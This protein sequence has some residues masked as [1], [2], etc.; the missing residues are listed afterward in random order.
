MTLNR[1]R[2]LLASGAALLAPE[3]LGRL[4]A[5]QEGPTRKVL[6]FT[7]SAGYQHAVITRDDDQPALAERILTEAGRAHGFEVVATKDGRLFEPDRIG[8]WD[9]FAFYT[10]GD[11]TTPGEDRQPPM[12]PEGKRALL[13]AVHAGKGFLG[14]HCATDTFLS[15][16]DQVD[17]YIRMVGGEFIVHGDQHEARLL[18][19]D[20]GFPGAGPLGPS[21]TINDEWYALKNLADD[22]HV[23]IAHDT[24][25]M[26]GPMY[27]RPNY[28][29][30]WARM[31]GQGRVFYTSMGHSEDVWTNPKYQGL[32][33]GALGFV[34]RRVDADIPPN[35]TE[36]TP[37]YKELPA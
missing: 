32:L 30:T 34:T 2:M 12:S 10:T 18:V 25:T 11:L 23:I 8:Q 13:D 35:I 7:K 1:R 20:A 24:G 29:Q 9:A 26:Q 15:P 5:D 3:A 37:G 21:F 22:L 16:A 33:I 28:P 36:V 19:A 27:R 6:F 4:R 31:H 14:M 17:P